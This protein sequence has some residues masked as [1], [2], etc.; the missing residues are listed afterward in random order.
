MAHSDK[1][2]DVLIKP[3][4]NESVDPRLAPMGTPRKLVNVRTRRAARFEKRPGT[5]SIGAS[6]LP[7][8]ATA[9]WVAEIASEPVVCADD[10]AFGNLVA[11]N[12]YRKNSAG[13]WDRLGRHGVSVP[14]RRF[15]V[16]LAASGSSSF[17]ADVG[18]EH[19]CAVV[20]GLLY[21]AYADV[22]AGTTVTIYQIDPDGIVLRR[23]SLSDAAEP[24]L[25]YANSVLYLVTREPGGSGTDIE[26]RTISSNLTLSS[27]TTLGSTLASATSRFDAAP[28]EGGT[29]WVIAYPESSIVM[30]IR[31]MS[32]T[33]SAVDDAVSTPAEATCIGITAFEGERVCVAYVSGG[34]LKALV[35]T[36]SSLSNSGAFNVRAAAGAETYAHQCG[37]VRVDTNTHFI[38]AGGT[39][40]DTE[41]LLSTIFTVTAKISTSAVT[42]GPIKHWHYGTTS[43][44]WTYGAAGQRRVL[45][46]AQ[47]GAGYAAGQTQPKSTILDVSAVYAFADAISYEHS[48]GYESAIGQSRHV[49]EVASL[50]SGRHV[51]VIPW[52]DP[53]P[54][55]GIDVVVWS[56][57]SPSES[58][59]AAH[60]AAH[61]SGGALYISGGA[62]QECAEAADPTYSVQI[63]E[64]GF[65]HYPAVTLN[66]GVA[67]GGALT[68][69]QEYNYCALYRWQD[70]VGRVHRGAP[71]AVK[72]A[73]P[74]PTGIWLTTRVRIATLSGSVKVGGM[75]GNPVAEVYRSWNG[76][77]YYYVGST[78][79]IDAVSVNDVSTT[80]DD[81]IADTTV[82]SNHVLYTSLDILPTEPPSGARLMCQGGQRLFT[83]GWRENTV[84]FSKLYVA[85][86]PWEFVDDDTFRISV[87]SRITALGWMDGALVIFCAS[88]IYIVTGD[89]PNDQGVGAFSDPRQLP[90]AV[91]ADSPHVVEVA[92]GLM[93]KGGGTIWLLPRGFGP[94]QPDGD[95]IQETLGRF[96][97]LRAAFK[98]ANADDDCTHFVLASA[99]LP[100][101]STYVAV[102]DNR[103]G[104]WSLDDIDGEVGAAAAVDGKFTWLLPQWSATTHVPARQFG[105]SQYQDY[106][107]QGASTWVEQRIEFGD[108][109]PFG[110][111]GQGRLG[112]VGVLGA[113]NGAANGPP[114]NAVFT[115]DES[116]QVVQQIAVSGSGNGAFFREIVPKQQA[117]TAFQLTI[118]D[119]QP[120]TFVPSH[121]INALGIE[122]DTE[123]GLRRPNV[124]ERV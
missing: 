15:G 122:V 28:V 90:A 120:S 67:T 124:G 62:L 22:T 34:T 105:V 80:Y 33:T 81:I 106:S 46:W 84:Q 16:A 57:A 56:D 123:P 100:G 115:I 117:G 40:S 116:V 64:N 53:G 118:Y 6:G 44:P 79:A 94:P 91:G 86:A 37:V 85:T 78:G 98:A 21:L 112:R 3:G 52:D 72:A 38:I 47:N 36:T 31:R 60:R 97:H 92:E 20:G 119:S 66:V 12:M 95:A 103:Y 18:Q 65:P 76:G 13:T 50:G 14:E 114:L 10:V 8:A 82:A 9:R 109:R 29:T 5:G 58:I 19:T 49:P 4:M 11:P 26:V 121:V 55:S 59:A 75:S 101:A 27:E 87:P 63:P 23:T 2:Q 41:P 70:S 71:S 77:P 17:A 113:F 32:G 25:V 35:A 96:P 42:V 7:P 102:R 54:L 48:A 69:G 111:L 1:Y 43:K 68:A 108:W 51:T 93:Y 99:D 45:V 83:V 61:E 73:S 107:S 110:V 104:S 30:R 74:S 24:R 89:G 39:D 88:A